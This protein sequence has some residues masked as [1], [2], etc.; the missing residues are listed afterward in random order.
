MEKFHGRCHCGAVTFEAEAELNP[1]LECNCSHCSV[2]G[3]LLAFVP[4]TQFRLLS[5]EAD[6]SEYRFNK[7]VI[8]HLFCKHCGVQPF[9]RG[10]D[11]ATGAETVAINVRTLAGVDAS[12]LTLTPFDGKSW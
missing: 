2:K 6:L 4:A 12:K 9:G 10:Q 5:G 7:K 11:P 8:A 1:I 3:L